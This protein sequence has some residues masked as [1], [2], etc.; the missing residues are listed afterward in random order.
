V[1]I[2]AAL[3]WPDRFN[4]WSFRSKIIRGFN[5][6]SASSHLLLKKCFR[7]GCYGPMIIAQVLG[8]ACRQLRWYGHQL[9]AQVRTARNL[10]RYRLCARR[11]APMPVNEL[12]ADPALEA[13]R[14]QFLA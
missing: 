11:Q 9:R 4:R 5:I 13:E 2:Q 3:A 7:D 10:A 12:I 8:H 6:S 1:S 14:S